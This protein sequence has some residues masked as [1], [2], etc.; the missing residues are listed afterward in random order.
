[1]STKT[2]IEH[3]DVLT[4]CSPMSNTIRIF[5]DG[6]CEMSCDHQ[7]RRA[8]FAIVVDSSTNERERFQFLENFAKN[9]IIPDCFRVHTTA[10]NWGSQNPARAELLAISHFLCSLEKFGGLDKN[11]EIY[12]DSAYVM[13]TIQNLEDTIID[14]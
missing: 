6:A 1:M 14:P 9:G 11:V 4:L 7:A 5:T 2:E 12:T 10:H 8:G 13:S 3:Q